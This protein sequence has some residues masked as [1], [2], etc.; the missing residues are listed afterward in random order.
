MGIT[1]SCFTKPYTPVNDIL[2]KEI[3]AV[4]EQYQ[5]QFL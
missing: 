5:K 3:K 1:N 4:I 2:E